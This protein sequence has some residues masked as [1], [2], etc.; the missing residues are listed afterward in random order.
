MKNRLDGQ[1]GMVLKFS[2][3][4]LNVPYDYK[5]GEIKQPPKLN[6]HIDTERGKV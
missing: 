4:F 2:I 3:Y 6:L 1:L 5:T